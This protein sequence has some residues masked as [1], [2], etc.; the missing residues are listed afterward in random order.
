MEEKKSI[1]VKVGIF[2]M[3]GILILI[4]FSLRTKKGKVV[5]AG[6]PI[7]AY[8]EEAR[9][10]E[11]GAPVL[12]MGV[13]A[14]RVMGVK[15]DPAKAKVQVKMMIAGEYKLPADSQAAIYLKSLLGQHYIHIK[16]GK[17]AETLRPNDEISTYEVSDI[18]TIVETVG[19]LS[20]DAKEFLSS[21]DENQKRVTEKITTLLDENRE[22]I[23]T[24]TK[25]L[26]DF[27][28]KVNQVAEDLVKL[29]RDLREG[30]GTLAQLITKP[31]MY[32]RI[33]DLLDNINSITAD[34]KEGRGTLGKLLADETLHR[35]LENTLSGLKDAANETKAFLSDN[36]EKLTE[37]VDK[38]DKSVSNF[39]EI[40]DKINQ[41]K[42]SLGKLINDPTLYDDAQRTLNQLE[43]TFKEGEEQGLLRTFVAVFFASLM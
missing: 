1:A 8:F 11:E 34:L 5:K 9:G 31:D 14:G 27:A 37:V 36:R 28:P 30:E 26:A 29:T 4:G 21:L 25:S 43:K 33:Y 40:S 15:F 39:M 7:I 17:S 32:N 13:E 12:L 10:L 35:E 24:A 2:C 3:V 23:K 18:N 20:K 41:G 19:D 16:Y 6:Y 38:I 42:G 22:N